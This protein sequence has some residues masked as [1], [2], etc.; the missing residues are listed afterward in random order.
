MTNIYCSSDVCLQCRRPGFDPWV[1]KM[2]WRK[3]WQPTPVFLPRESHGLRSL[4]G[5]RPWGH[6]E[7]DTTERL[8]HTHTHTHTHRCLSAWFNALPHLFSPY[9]K[10]LLKYSCCTVLQVIGVQYQSVSSVAQSYLTLCNSMD[11][12]TPGL[13]VC[14]QLPEFTQTNVHWVGDS[15]QPS[16]PLSSPSPSTFNFSQ[17]QGLFQ[18]VISLHQMAKV[19][20]FIF[21]ISPSSEYSGLISFRM[22]WLD[23]LA[24]QG[25]LKSLF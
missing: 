7:S 18:W 8:T 25:T 14:H 6:K 21:S 17:H 24:V 12:S 1:R 5:Y 11:C 2:P 3:K 19:L 4:V 23:L 15:I 13:P 10:I 9:L 16:H 22:D 20:S